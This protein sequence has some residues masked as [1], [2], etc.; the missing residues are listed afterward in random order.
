MKF[1][2]F[3]NIVQKNKHIAKNIDIYDINSAFTLASIIV[4]AKKQS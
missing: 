1:D 4:L 2:K 3:D